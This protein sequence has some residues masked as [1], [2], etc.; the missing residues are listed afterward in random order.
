MNEG[1]KIFGTTGSD[2]SAAYTRIIMCTN[3]EKYA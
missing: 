2:F 1:I 3:N